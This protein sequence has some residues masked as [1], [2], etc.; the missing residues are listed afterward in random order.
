HIREKILTDPGKLL[1]NIGPIAESV[2][3]IRIKTQMRS[4][5]DHNDALISRIPLHTCSP[6]P[7]RMIS[8][9]T[10]KQIQHRIRWL[11]MSSVD[12]IYDI[13]ILPK[14]YIEIHTHVQHFRETVHRKK[15]HGISLSFMIQTLPPQGPDGS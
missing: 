4:R 10:V 12:R 2:L 13:D 6:G 8:I 3:H 14:D 9:V 1:R 5:H 15:S 11:K 7:Y